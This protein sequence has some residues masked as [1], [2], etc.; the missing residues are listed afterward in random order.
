MSKVKE[1]DSKLA[2]IEVQQRF[3]SQKAEIAHKMEE[4]IAL[5]TKDADRLE[6]LKKEHMVLRN[7]AAEVHALDD[8][9]CILA[10]TAKLLDARKKKTQQLKRKEV[11]EMPC[12]QQRGC[13]RCCTLWSVCCIGLSKEIIH[14]IF[15]MNL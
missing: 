10:E 13:C 1:L 2:E 14:C 12:T 3:V 7:K 5:F 4:E 15:F 6:I 9:L 8:E 11:L